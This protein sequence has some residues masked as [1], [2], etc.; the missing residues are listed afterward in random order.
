MKR[1]LVACALVSA[2]AFALGGPEEA[3]DVSVCRPLEERV[4]DAIAKV[5]DSVVTV[6]AEQRE[7][8]GESGQGS[9]SVTSGGSGVI[10]TTDGYVLTND[11]V[12]LGEKRVHVGLR[13][14]RTLAGEVTGRDR[15]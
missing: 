15:I 9:K 2:A 3:E 6:S 10:F 5:R 4:E 12:T 11:H 1:A 8:L 13:D 7:P 14:G